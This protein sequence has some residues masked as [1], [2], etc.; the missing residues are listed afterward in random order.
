MTPS[1]RGLAFDFRIPGCP[2]LVAAGSIPM[3][4]PDE[5]FKC[6]VFTGYDKGGGEKHLNGTAFLCASPVEG[7]T[8][9]LGFHAVTA[10]HVVERARERSEK[11][12]FRV[13]LTEPGEDGSEW[14]ET[15]IKDW[16]FHPDSRV[17][18]AAHY[19]PAWTPR[20][21]HKFLST[22]GFLTNEIIQKLRIGPG[23]ELFFPGLVTKHPGIGRNQP[24]VRFGNIAAMPQ[25]KVDTN[26]GYSH[27]YLAD[28]R[29]I[30]GMSGSP[31]FS[32]L[33][34]DRE[35]H[36]SVNDLDVLIPMG[37]GEFFVLGMIIGHWD[38]HLGEETFLID[39]DLYRER[40]NTGIALIA[41]S[42]QI[43]ELLN[44]EEFV[45]LR[46]EKL[47]AFQAANLPTD[48]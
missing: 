5:I 30:G 34:S 36:E 40:I 32:Y 16:R 6:V 28:S 2:K 41:P 20:Y 7:T 23:D 35:Y 3:L 13:N 14:L 24:I 26:L 22:K 39:P 46:L 27:L 12:Y 25:E 47:E 33:P 37:G 29:S 15:R 48:D 10:R 31:V 8:L 18:L 11:L 17:D 44:I 43:L 45:D 38:D 1:R 21:D 42:W 9:L 4:I 19:I